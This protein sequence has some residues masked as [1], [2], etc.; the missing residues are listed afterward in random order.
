M[1]G[2]FFL[3]LAVSAGEFLCTGQIYLATI[4]YLL[5]A[6]P[7]GRPLALAAL[8]CYTLAASLPPALLVLFCYKGKQALALSEF[9]RKKMPVVKIANAALF[10]LFAFLA[11]LF[12]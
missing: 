8:L 5:R 11:F 2:I 7:G 12:F 4:L 9:A 1:A 3:G 6:N 10:A